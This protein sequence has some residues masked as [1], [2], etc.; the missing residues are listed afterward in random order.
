M[1]GDVLNSDALNEGEFISEQLD[2]RQWTQTVRLWRNMF[3]RLEEDMANWFWWDE[4]IKPKQLWNGEDEKERG[5]EGRQCYINHHVTHEENNC[6]SFLWQIQSFCLP[7]SCFPS[8]ASIISPDLMLMLM[9]PYQLLWQSVSGIHGS[10][11]MTAT[12]FHHAQTFLQAFNKCLDI[13][14]KWPSWSFNQNPSCISPRW[15][16]SLL[17]FCK[18]F[19]HFCIF[20]Y[21]FI[22]FLSTSFPCW[23]PF[24]VCSLAS[25]LLHC[26]NCD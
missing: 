10:Q 12:D 21:W 9:Y 22:S 8:A 25:L 23:S 1:W 6:E 5:G 17:L 15:A 3:W 26:K 16:G 24:I 20:F 11:I 14:F 13:F 4:G 2:S 18:Y 19:H 7:S